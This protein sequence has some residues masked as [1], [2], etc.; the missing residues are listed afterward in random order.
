MP[1]GRYSKIDGR[2]KAARV[3]QSRLNG[4]G[5]ELLHEMTEAQDVIDSPDATEEEVAEAEDL[6]R[7]STVLIRGLGRKYRA[8]GQQWR[9]AMDERIKIERQV[10]RRQVVYPKLGFF[11]K[12][13]VNRAVR[14]MNV[15]TSTEAQ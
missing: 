11:E 3:E 5:R 13:R 12:K 10:I 2:I 7:S 4:L 1:S 6:V 15:G 8:V 9:G 14:R